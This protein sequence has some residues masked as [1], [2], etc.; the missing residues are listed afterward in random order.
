[1]PGSRKVRGRSAMYKVRAVDDPPNVALRMAIAQEVC[2]LHIVKASARN[3]NSDATRQQQSADKPQSWAQVAKNAVG[4]MKTVDSPFAAQPWQ[5]P[6]PAQSSHHQWAD[7]AWNNSNWKD[8][9]WQNP[10]QHGWNDSTDQWGTQHQEVPAHNEQDDDMNWVC[11]AD[12]MGENLLDMDPQAGYGK[13]RRFHMD[14]P[15]PSPHDETAAVDTTTT[16]NGG[17]R[18]PAPA[19]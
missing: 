9:Q 6:T 17:S 1:M 8:T 11:I 19:G 13:A 15:R 12:L 4:V 5:A 18:D 14:T 3:H 7:T 10:W 16:A 2:Q